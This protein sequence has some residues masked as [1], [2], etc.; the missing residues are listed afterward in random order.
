MIFRFNGAVEV[1]EGLVPS[2]EVHVYLLPPDILLW[3]SKTIEGMNMGGC[4]S[5]RFPE[6]ELPLI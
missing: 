5:V 6:G 4:L 2:V 3:K 1:I